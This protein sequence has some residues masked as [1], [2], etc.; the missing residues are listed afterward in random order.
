[1]QKKSTDHYDLSGPDMAVLA[2][3]I[4]KQFATR[5]LLIPLLAKKLGSSAP[6]DDLHQVFL[7][8]TNQLRTEARTQVPEYRTTMRYKICLHKCFRDNTNYKTA[9]KLSLAQ[10]TK[11]LVTRKK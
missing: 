7:D 5:N 8:T 9:S 3:T 1:M 2:A 6:G 10:K 11:D 4:N